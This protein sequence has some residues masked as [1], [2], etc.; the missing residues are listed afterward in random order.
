MATF[1]LN[2]ANHQ[3]NRTNGILTQSST[4]QA[5]YEMQATLTNSPQRPNKDY[6]H[7]I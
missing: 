6:T 3:W 7:V 2:T 1:Q 5:M 4:V